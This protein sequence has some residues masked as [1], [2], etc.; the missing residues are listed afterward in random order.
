ML[1]LNA[2]LIAVD[3]KINKQ[4]SS[5]IDYF[6]FRER[7]DAVVGCES[8]SI[9]SHQT[10][11]RKALRSNA[12]CDSD[13]C[14]ITDF[15]EAIDWVECTAC[16]EW[17]HIPC[18]VLSTSELVDVETSDSYVCLLCTGKKVDDLKPLVES[19]LAN[20]TL[21][22]KNLEIQAQSLRDRIWIIQS[23]VE[24]NMGPLQM[25]LLASQ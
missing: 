11:S 13:L 9:A 24:D 23:D 5:Y 16:N 12:K 14:L 7:L 3:E 18:E 1:K 22:Q 21:T 10:T 17:R 2:E 19:K 4:D 20:L 15:D 8:D 6:N 25:K